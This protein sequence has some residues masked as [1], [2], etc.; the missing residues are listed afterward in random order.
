MARKRSSTDV[1]ADAEVALVDAS[2]PTSSTPKRTRKA[3][4][5]KKKKK[6]KAAKAKRQPPKPKPV[7]KPRA[8]A[9][10]KAPRA[11]RRQMDRP[12]P[13]TADEAS[14]DRKLDLRAIAETLEPREPERAEEPHEAKPTEQSPEAD[15]AVDDSKV[16]AEDVSESIVADPVAEVAEAVNDSAIETASEP[17]DA[18]AEA[19]AIDSPSEP[20]PPPTPEGDYADLEQHGE[21]P[22]AEEGP[23]E[24]V[25][26]SGSLDDGPV[27]LSP[28]EALELLAR[29]N[30]PEPERVEEERPAGESALGRATVEPVHVPACRVLTFESAEVDSGM[31]VAGST[32]ARLYGMVRDEGLDVEL[33]PI[34]QTLEEFVAAWDETSPGTPVA[35]LANLNSAGEF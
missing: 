34:C 30:S 1:A 28:E 16:V 25:P 15:K 21:D 2:A 35:I 29:L 9:A 33:G 23:S 7:K 11:Q 22:P 5:P 19:P 26:D 14:E 8:K 3:Q 31:R 10:R 6:K 27:E 17:V 12:M 4:G 20:C 32:L 13:V 18:V 24:D